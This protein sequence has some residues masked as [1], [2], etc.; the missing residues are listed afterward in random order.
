LFKSLT[1]PELKNLC[2]ERGM[3]GY[4]TLNKDNLIRKCLNLP[5][6][7]EEK[8]KTT[9]VLVSPTTIHASFTFSVQT[10][11]KKS[12]KKRKIEDVKAEKPKKKSKT[13]NEAVQC[14]CKVPSARRVT[15][16]EGSNQGREFYTCKSNDCSFFSW[17]E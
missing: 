13:E 12:G 3:K 9:E 11:E 10:E 7:N 5:L 8:V 6:L 15:K 16:K 4:S 14:Y 2:K 1:I 17:V